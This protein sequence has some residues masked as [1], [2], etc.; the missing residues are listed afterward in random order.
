VKR[1]FSVETNIQTSSLIPYLESG[2]NNFRLEISL[3]SDNP[4]L[5]EKTPFPFLIVSDGSFTRLIEARILSDAESVIKRVFFLQQSDK[6]RLTP[7]DMQ[8]L[9]NKDIDRFWQKVFLKSSIRST[10]KSSRRS[11][12]VLLR[13]I[14]KNGEFSPFQSLFY[15]TFKNSYFHP[16]CSKCGKSLKLCRDDNLLS[17]LELQPYSSSLK[18]YLFCPSCA[19]ESTSIDFYVFGL[20]TFDPPFLKDRLGLIKDWAH[21]FDSPVTPDHFPC[22]DC[23]EKT[24]CYGIDNLS[25]QRI[26]PFSFYPFYSLLLE[27]GS[28]IAFDFLA[29]ISGATLDEV[30]ASL[31]KKRAFGRIKCLEALRQTVGASSPFLFDHENGKLFFE[32]LYLKL[33]FLGELAR[34]IFSDQG[35]L[36]PP[37][38]LLSLDRIWVKLADQAGLLPLFWNFSLEVMDIGIASI[39]PS[40]LSRDPESQG[41]HFMGT[42]WFY[43]LLVNNQQTI[44]QVQAGLEKIMPKLTSTDVKFSEL[45][46][47][48]KLRPIFSSNNIFWMPK[49]RRLD[50]AWH[51][52]WE[53]SLDL[54]AGLLVASLNR[55]RPWSIKAFWQNYNALR[56]E[57]KAELFKRGALIAGEFSPSDNLAISALLNQIL[58]R[59]RSNITYQKNHKEVR[60]VE[61]TLDLSTQIQSAFES[62]KES[63]SGDKELGDTVILSPEEPGKNEIYAEQPG[64]TEETLILSTEDRPVSD[65]VDDASQAV[66]DIEETIILESDPFEDKRPPSEQVISGPEKDDL[67]ETVILPSGKEAGKSVIASQQK[68]L[69]KDL[70]NDRGEVTQ[71]AK[72]KQKDTLEE[73]DFLT[74]TVILKTGKEQNSGIENE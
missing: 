15:C 41:I 33:T 36:S 63:A 44:Q 65:R 45:I 2:E 64:D 54:G 24:K 59:W 4:E 6:Y 69:T 66:E 70:E 7:D 14:K 43:A 28:L 67:P 32:V 9:N 68:N 55:E 34:M 37:D 19:Q 62:K 51:P 38:S 23:T 53:K 18:R 40:Y 50:D 35:S 12:Y 71:T 46:K 57:L 29:L 73:E 42:A 47:Q 17:E 49:D 1:I 10:E 72:C 16:P 25:V 48:Q 27:A 52:A 30:Q 5:L 58:S 39:K 20:D 26:V 11:Q 22:I 3:I 21:L 8:P 31:S 74:E 60:E 61:A 13:Q 56:D